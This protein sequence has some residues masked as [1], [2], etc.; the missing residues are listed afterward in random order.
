MLFDG[1]AKTLARFVKQ[2]LA[3]YC[4]IEAPETDTT[5]VCSD[6]S[7]MSMI[8]IHGNMSLT[9]HDEFVVLKNSLNTALKPYLADKGHSIQFTFSRNPDM[10]EQVVRDALAGSLAT[11]RR[12]NLDMDDMFEEKV[13]V[14]GRTCADESMYLTLWTNPSALTSEDT[15]RYAAK[16]KGYY[17]GVPPLGDTQNPIK[18]I[19]ILRDKHASFAASMLDKLRDNSIRATLLEVHDALRCIR[20]EVSPDFTSKN[21]RPSLI[22][23]K[24]PRG[25][26]ET[27]GDVDAILWPKIGYQ[28]FPRDAED[29]SNKDYVKVGSIYYAPMYIEIGPQDVKYFNNLFSAITNSNSDMPWRIS[30]LIEGDPL[31]SL[32]VKK[33]LA[34][35]I[36]FA[37]MGNKKI[38]NAFQDIQADL[39][40]GSIYAK[41][42]ISMVTWANDVE[43]LEYRKSLLARSVEGWG[44]CEV[45]EEKGDP[46]AGLVSTVPAVVADSV[47]N[48]HAAPIPDIIDMLPLVRA[49]SPW[50]SGSVLFK[51]LSGKL[52]PYQPGS[53]KQTTWIDLMFAKPGAGKSVLANLINLG[54]IVAAGNER[55]PYI[56]IIDIGPSSSGLI[57][58]IIDALPNH[59]KHYAVYKRIQMREEYATNPMDTQLGMQYPTPAEAAFIKNFVT[60]LATPVGKKTPYEGMAEMIG[61]VIDEAYKMYS[62][63]ESPNPYTKRIDP[64]VD[65]VLEVERF[66]YD[67]HST[68]W[69]ATDFLFE[70][71]YIREA[72]LAQRYAVP[73]L[74]DLSSVARTSQ[75]IK[76]VYGSVTTSTGENI[77][78]LFSRM[79][80]SAIREYPV[81]SRPTKFDLGDAR[82]VSLDLD[83]VAKSGGD[84][85]ERQTAVMYM[86]SMFVLTKNFH[87]NKE[88]VHEFPPLYRKYQE[89]RIKE[90]HAS[91]KR[92]CLDEFH[93]TSSTTIVRDQVVVEM[94]EGR[95]WNIQVCLASQR[96]EDFDE[97]ML[98]F[99]TN[100]YM[101]SPG[102]GKVIQR[103]GKRFGLSNTDLYNLE[104]N[105]H[106]PN[107]NGVTLMY[108]VETKDEGMKSHI[109]NSTVGPVELWAFSTTKEDVQIRDGLTAAIGGRP[110]RAILAKDYPSGSAK[111]EYER[112]KEN[113]SIENNESKN[114]DIIGDMV[115]GLI[116]KARKEGI[117]E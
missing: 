40:N 79:I 4:G 62:N 9:G 7:Y 83:D 76:D 84:I 113:L 16:Q 106:G 69:D 75:P 89:E 115:K 55:I 35:I 81:L 42:R 63:A 14:M 117:V 27:D 103:L 72:S 110:A 11:A 30:F 104:Y 19:T 73:I 88:L 71:G 18:A 59:L 37:N 107:R 66:E 43:T 47:A 74:Q 91:P 54:L 33:G 8:K 82:I 24:V 1:L 2:N 93:R 52:W 57:S 101:F 114:I 21:W 46:V 68:W 38:N 99:A 32:S 96:E 41:L 44:Y 45:L 22:G 90:F 26:P 64:E 65:R 98:E 5:F 61:Q 87:L 13:K 100:I 25:Y 51:T 6:G 48:P 80:S 109:V 105:T 92:L 34:S 58:L 49:S 15:K 36:G 70:K 31:S 28:I 112:R 29:G 97:S 60:L 111:S 53:S 77:I 94:R 23:D 3:D 20:M 39:Q 67:E 86:L 95:K 12:L 50:D 85:A 116:D 78:D 17:K 108:R 102:S 56:S 10:A